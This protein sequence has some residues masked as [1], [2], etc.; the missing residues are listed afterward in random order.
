[1]GQTAKAGWD[2]LIKSRLEVPPSKCQG[3][4]Q[5]KKFL[6]AWWI[7]GATAVP[8]ETLSAI[9]KGQITSKE[10][11][12]YVQDTPWIEMKKPTVTM[13]GGQPQTSNPDAQ[14]QLSQEE[15]NPKMSRASLSPCSIDEKGWLAL[16]IFLALV[17][18]YFQ[19]LPTKPF[20]A[21]ANSIHGIGLW[22]K[23]QTIY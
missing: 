20:N 8:D 2:L 9:G 1:M 16:L 6:G 15:R 12:L 14:S 7:S 11:A 18:W 17:K 22:S 10:T 4:G 3:V 13:S 5:E 19:V 21:E 23:G